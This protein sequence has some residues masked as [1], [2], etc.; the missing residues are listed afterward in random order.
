MLHPPI[1]KEL[2][3]HLCG[4]HDF[5]HTLTTGLLR[6]QVS[7]KVVSNILGHSNVKITLD[8]YCHKEVGDFGEPLHNVA[9]QLLPDVMKLA[10]RPEPCID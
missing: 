9:A 10:F 7:A 3:I 6:G 2:G 1:A 8:T 4:W 5:R